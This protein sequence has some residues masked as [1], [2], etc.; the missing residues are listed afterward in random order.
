MLHT[1]ERR[2][3]KRYSTRLK[4]YEENTDTLLGYCEDL[5]ISGLRLMSET[6][7]PANKELKAR[8]DGNGAGEGITLTLFRIWNSIT[9]TTPRYYYSGMHIVGPGE[10][11]LDKLQDLIDDLFVKVNQDSQ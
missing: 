4:V 3:A 9:D 11:T 8:L 10:E 5:S 1:P 7:L 2:K 6:P